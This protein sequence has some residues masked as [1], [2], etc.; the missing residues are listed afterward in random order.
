MTMP[1][2]AVARAG[3]AHP[4]TVQPASAAMHVIARVGVER[5]AFPVADVEAVLE[6]PKLLAA[7]SAPPEL[8]GQMVHGER[9]LRA[10]DAAWVFGVA[11]PQ[12]LVAATAL[13]LRAA[14]AR[15]VLLVDDVEDLAS[16]D[17]DSTRTPPHGSDPYG[18][19]R[20]V[21]VPPAGGAAHPCDTAALIAV[22]N[23][24]AVIARAA[25][26]RGARGEA[27]GEA[28]PVRA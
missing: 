11:R 23:A 14:D 15:V 7:P 8:A 5:F 2:A 21:C 9:T 24:A 13:V 17:P 4:E 10:Y 12:A 27:R 18:V 28:I 1:S 25:A 20:G 3:R 26:L 22:V 16:L 6:T 19:L